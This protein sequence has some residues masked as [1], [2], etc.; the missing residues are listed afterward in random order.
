MSER[1]QRPSWIR[2][3][4]SIETGDAPGRVRYLRALAP[5]QTPVCYHDHIAPPFHE[6]RYRPP[7][8]RRSSREKL[9]NNEKP[10]TMENYFELKNKLE[11]LGDKF[12][13]INSGFFQH[14][15]RLEQMMGLLAE[16]MGIST[17]SKEYLYLTYGAR[18]HDIGKAY[19]LDYMML[20]TILTDEQRKITHN[21]PE[22]GAKLIP[23]EFA[24]L[25]EII[26][27]HHRDEWGNGYPEK[28]FDEALLATVSNPNA[29]LLMQWGVRMVDVLDAMWSDRPYRKGLDLNYAKSELRKFAGKQFNH[30]LVKL[31]LDDDIISDLFA[32]HRGVDGQPGIYTLHEEFEKYRFD[33]EIIKV[34]Q[35]G[36][37]SEKLSDG[38][39]YFSG[40]GRWYDLEYIPDTF[41]SCAHLVRR[42]AQYAQRIRTYLK[43]NRSKLPMAA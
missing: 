2:S 6:T 31:L 33:D 27:T 25:K 37:D 19:C 3:R 40:N 42:T 23:E 10:W 28:P 5:R 43:F 7:S 12:P 8:A 35:Y 36:Y 15:L 17:F 14:Q 21:H 38:S 41:K 9:T 29:R 39:I 22:D 13:P 20:P 18:Y 24:L 4:N 26:R 16:Q 32:L 11:A 30:E 34:Q 1:Q